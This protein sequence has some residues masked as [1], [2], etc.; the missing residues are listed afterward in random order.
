[1]SNVK[2]NLTVSGRKKPIES[3]IAKAKGRNQRYSGPF[4]DKRAFPNWDV[5]TPIGVEAS[6]MDG[7]SCLGDMTELSFHSLLPIPKEILFAPYNPDSFQ[8]EKERYPEWF[9]KYPSIKAGFDWE[10]E[11]WGVSLG[12]FNVEALHVIRESWDSEAVYWFN[13][14]TTIPSIFKVVSSHFPELNFHLAWED[15][16]YTGFYTYRAGKII[17]SDTWVI[18]NMEN[19]G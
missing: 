3:F 5:F 6:M 12:A 16:T 8:R 10:M 7:E 13:T 18:K 11:N 9:S 19:E 2:N 15:W 17:E 1:M 14:N 4:N